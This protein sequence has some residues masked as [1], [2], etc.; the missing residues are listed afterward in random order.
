MIRRHQE[1]ILKYFKVR[2]DNG[3]VEELNNRAKA[4]SHRAFGYRSATTFRLAL[5]HGMGKL[6]APQLMHRFL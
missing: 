4:I 6:P 2:I 5:Y 3:A 1:G